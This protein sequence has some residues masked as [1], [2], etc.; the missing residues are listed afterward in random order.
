MAGTGSNNTK[1]T[2][3]LS[4]KAIQA[5]ADSLLI[6]TPPYNKPND[7]GNVQ[8]LQVCSRCNQTPICL[9]H[10]PGRTGQLL[11]ADQMAKIC[12][13]DEVIAVKEA[14]ADLHYLQIQL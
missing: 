8:S 6:V 7:D 1:K 2:I 11:S 9:Y 14:S 3:E 4:K 13:I 5:G 12:E 10:V